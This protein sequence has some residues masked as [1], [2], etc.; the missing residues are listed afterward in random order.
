MKRSA[1]CFSAIAVALVALALFLRL[2]RL[3]N[4][5]VD[6]DEMFSLRVA[7]APAPRAL[8]MIRKDLVH[9]PL[10][11]VLLKWTLP[12]R[13]S[14]SAL[15]LRLLSLAAGAALLIPVMLA[16]SAIVPLRAPAILAACL[17]ALNQTQIFYSQ[18]ARSYALF[19]FFAAMLLLW[20]LLMDR[21]QHTRTYWLL[22]TV[23]MAASL[24]IHYFACFYCAAVV[25]PAVVASGLKRVRMLAV[26]TLGLASAAFLPWIY[27]ETTVYHEKGGLSLN[28]GWNNRPSL[29]DLKATLADSLGEPDF[30]KAANV[31]V[32][33]GAAL[34]GLG[35]LPGPRADDRSLNLR[36]RLTLG[37]W[38]LMP[39]IVTF[40]LAREPL[41]LPIFGVR[42]VLPSMLAAL[43][44]I[45]AGLWRLAQYASARL[46]VKVL[47]TGAAALGVLQL[48]PVWK[49]W[50]GPTREPYAAVAQRLEQ[51]HSGLPVYTS[52][53]YGIAEP[54]SFYLQGR[55]AVQ[56]LPLYPA[57]LPDDL[58]LLYR[59]AAQFEVAAVQAVL[60]SFDVLQ[61][62]YYSA[63]QSIAGTRLLVLRR[64]AKL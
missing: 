43:I 58:I 29:Y 48:F 42:H 41:L 32:L 37:L 1:L 27:Q 56:Q 18:Q 35:L 52:W 21:F 12:D 15:D 28:L 51:M 36:V 46:R 45:S 59:P 3:P 63:D 61:Q 7:T 23:L 55:L 64:H 39:P 49:H 25:L 5:S 13:G 34:L 53:Y 8:E 2:A 20:S 26:I 40:F 38:A 62:S 60:A 24:Y 54:V 47:V 31:E 57:Q 33:V 30:Y 16:G 44:L 10:Y 50:H 6:G 17:L 11:Y 19:C 14:I 22:G 9:P 4:E